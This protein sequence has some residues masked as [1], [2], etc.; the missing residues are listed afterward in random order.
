MLKRGDGGRLIDLGRVLVN[1]GRRRYLMLGLDEDLGESA[2][3]A[4]AEFGS[5]RDLLF[6]LLLL[7]FLLFLIILGCE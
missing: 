4:T 7:L 5:K 2:R 6:L 3:D 1:L